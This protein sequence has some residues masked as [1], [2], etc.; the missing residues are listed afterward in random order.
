MTFSHPDIGLLNKAS[1][2]DFFVIS[3][4]KCGGTAIKRGLERCGHAVIHAHTN[5][6]TWDA[7]SNGDV[8]RANNVGMEHVLQ[9]RLIASSRPLYLFFGYRD[10]VSW[11]LSLGA[12]WRW[13]DS[14]RDDAWFQYFYTPEERESLTRSWSG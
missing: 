7:V 2:T 4:P 9:A 3:S 5:I 10:P 14:V 8:L 11:Y 1:D 13:V 12:M 6:T